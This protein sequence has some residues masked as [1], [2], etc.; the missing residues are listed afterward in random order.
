VKIKNH[1]M[2][3]SSNLKKITMISVMMANT[4]LVV[5]KIKPFMFGEHTM[6]KPNLLRQG[7]I[8]IISGRVSKVQYL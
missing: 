1:N 7:E 2:Q 5:Q 4:S 8:E 3:V 6:S